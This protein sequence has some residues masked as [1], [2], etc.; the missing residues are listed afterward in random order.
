M[1]RNLERYAS[2]FFILFFTETPPRS[3]CQNKQTA[4]EIKIACLLHFLEGGKI[5]YP[6]IPNLRIWT[7]D[8]TRLK[9][10]LYETKRKRKFQQRMT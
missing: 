7:Q 5:F 1:G 9:L 4:L 3:S 2:G 6:T 10:I 8:G